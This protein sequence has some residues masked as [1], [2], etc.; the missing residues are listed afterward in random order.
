MSTHRRS[1][2]FLAAIAFLIV[3][4]TSAQADDTPKM[5][6]GS[7]APPIEIEHWFSTG[8]FDKVSRLRPGKVY[9]IE[10][11]A[12]WCPPCR[13]A[14]P[15]I[16]KLQEK[17]A[18]YDVQIISVTREDVETVEKFLEKKIPGD[19]KKTFRDITKTYCLAS[20]PDKS[21]TRDYF[22]AAQQTGIPTA[23]IV[24]RTGRVEWIGS[25]FSLETPLAQVVQD[26][27][28]RTK[29]KTSFETKRRLKSEK[30]NL[31][32]LVKDEKYAEAAKYIGTT[33]KNY[34][35]TARKQKKIEQ[36]QMMLLGQMANSE[37]QYKKLTREFKDAPVLLNSASWSV[38]EAKQKDDKVP[39]SLVRAARK[40]MERS[41]KSE[42][43]AAALD[44]LAH[45]Y[46]L[47][48]KLAKAI[49]AQVKAVEKSSD[50]LKPELAKFLEQLQQQAKQ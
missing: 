8:D 19:S 36:F 27:W 15:H 6:I 18:S 3:F 9:V 1:A 49:D 44:T 38:V 7:K 5:T 13:K 35:G 45:L 30:S 32:K 42:P 24:G 47:E 20:D 50:K 41:V 48:G 46:H 12:T 25:P 21:V 37:K 31:S 22:Y 39:A 43:S 16:A 40:A 10:F 14:I 26:Q 34:S 28:D 29:F 33:L 4:A 11:W 23:F 17:F 2:T